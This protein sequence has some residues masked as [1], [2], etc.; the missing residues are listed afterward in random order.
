MGGAAPAAPPFDVNS[1]TNVKLWLKSGSGVTLVGGKFSAWADGSSAGNNAT[2]GTAG[3]RPTSVTVDGDSAPDFDGTDDV[4]VVPG[5]LADYCSFLGGN[6]H[7]FVV[8][9]P[10]TLTAADAN[11]YLNNPII[12]ENGGYWGLFGKTVAGTRYAQTYVYAGGEVVTPIHANSA[13]PIGGAR[14]L[15]ETKLDLANTLLSLR[16]AANAAVSVNCGLIGALT[17]VVSIGHGYA[18]S[19]FFDGRIL[20]LILCQDVQSAGDVTSVRNYLASEHGVTV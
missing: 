10:D 18:A 7:L 17:G 9:E 11:G 1:L 20:E 3:N 5:T 12:G 16:V 14:S 6:F 2:Q 13:I 8:V 4:M 19:A 15:I